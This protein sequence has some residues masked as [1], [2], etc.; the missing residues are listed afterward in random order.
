MD[1]TENTM[2]NMMNKK[3]NAMFALYAPR[4]LNSLAYFFIVYKFG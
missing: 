3:Y 2:A 1:A 4:Y